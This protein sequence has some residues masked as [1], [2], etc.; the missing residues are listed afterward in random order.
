MK[1]EKQREDPYKDVKFVELD[2]TDIFK[3]EKTTLKDRILNVV[4]TKLK[5]MKLKKPTGLAGNEQ[6]KLKNPGESFNYSHVSTIPDDPL[7][8]HYAYERKK[9]KLLTPDDFQENL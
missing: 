8:D 6:F 3:R 1:K 7:N 9:R 5:K 2:D 4:D